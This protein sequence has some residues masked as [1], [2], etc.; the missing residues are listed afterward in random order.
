MALPPITRPAPTY[1]RGPVLWDAVLRLAAGPLLTGLLVAGL[2]V[3]GLLLG[4]GPREAHGAATDAGPPPQMDLQAHRPGD[5]V[6]LARCLHL[7]VLDLLDRNGPLEPA[8]WVTL[9]VTNRCTEPVR[10]LLVD[11][12]LVDVVGQVYGRPLWVLQRGEVLRPGRSKTDRYPVPDAADH[13][14]REWAVRIRY[15]ETP[16]HRISFPVPAAV[17]VAVPR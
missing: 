15:V 8:D 17:R 7:S 16:G 10:Y 4:P 6:V 13:M 12:F 11:L 3:A 14:P 1:P 2:L 5:V 9:R